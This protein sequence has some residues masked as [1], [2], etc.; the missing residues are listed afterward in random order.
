[1]KRREFTMLLAALLALLL[2]VSACQNPSRIQSI[3][4]AASGFDGQGSSGE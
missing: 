4:P 3:Q 2:T 1:M